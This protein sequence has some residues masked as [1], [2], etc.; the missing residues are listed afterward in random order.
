MLLRLV[1]V[2]FFALKLLFNLKKRKRNCNRLKDETYVEAS[3]GIVDSRLI[4]WGRDVPQLRG[5]G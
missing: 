2:N 4:S 5:V 1:P 3:P